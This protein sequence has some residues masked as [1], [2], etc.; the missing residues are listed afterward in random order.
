MPDWAFHWAGYLIAIVAGLLL[1]LAL[2]RDRAK[3]R[4]RCR[5]CWYDLSDL[6]DAPTTCPECG[7]A[8]TKPRHLRKTRRHK[9]LAFVWLL[10]M[11]VGGYGM[12]VL[13]RVNERGWYGAVPTISMLLAAPWIN[14][15]WVYTSP[16]RVK[17]RDELRERL[18]QGQGLPDWLSWC[19]G[20]YWSLSG[21]KNVWPRS[22]YEMNSPANNKNAVADYLFVRFLTHGFGSH[23]DQIEYVKRSMFRG[24]GLSAYGVPIFDRERKVIGIKVSMVSKGPGDRPFVVYLDRTDTTAASKDKPVQPYTQAVSQRGKERQWLESQEITLWFDSDAVCASLVWIESARGVDLGCYRVE[25]WID[26]FSQNF[27]PADPSILEED[28]RI[29]FLDIKRW[30]VVSD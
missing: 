11:V 21:V 10:V 26:P 9:R 25:W 29:V 23:N 13:P 14:D 18:Y 6:G 28:T 30:G 5:K 15:R 3:G 2:F 24:S 7:K 8:H 22:T 16:E 20:K 27:D 4:S 19:T 17:V 1:L 12:W